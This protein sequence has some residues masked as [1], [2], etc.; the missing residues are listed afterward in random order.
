MTTLDWYE[1]TCAL[2]ARY[3]ET[4]SVYLKLTTDGWYLNEERCGDGDYAPVL[5]TSLRFNP[6]TLLTWLTLS[7]SQEIILLLIPV[8]KPKPALRLGVGGAYPSILSEKALQ[9]CIASVINLDYYDTHLAFGAILQKDQF[10]G[11]RSPVEEIKLYLAKLDKSS[12]LTPI[13]VRYTDEILDVMF[14][15]TTFVVRPT[16]NQIGLLP[17][18]HQE[19]ESSVVQLNEHVEL[20]PILHPSRPPILTKFYLLVTETFC[21]ITARTNHVAKTCICPV[22]FDLTSKERGHLLKIQAYQN[23]LQKCLSIGEQV[24]ADEGSKDITP[25]TVPELKN[26]RIGLVGD[27]HHVMTFLTNLSRASSFHTKLASKPSAVPVS[28]LPSLFVVKFAYGSYLYAKSVVNVFSIAEFKLPS[29]ITSWS[30]SVLNVK[31]SRRNWLVYLM[32]HNGEGLLMNCNRIT[33]LR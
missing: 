21:R 14:E 18:P 23:L 2:L 5:G 25:L 9:T 24:L 12:G 15:Q 28:D 7:P 22:S 26:Y 27:L 31:N 1:L 4:S 17:L 19:A 10:W 29:N 3:K 11:R 32:D 33:I 8:V 13:W 16:E 20:K 6:E 30:I